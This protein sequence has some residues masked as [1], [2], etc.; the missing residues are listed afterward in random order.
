MTHVTMEEFKSP[1]FRLGGGIL[2][3]DMTFKRLIAEFSD[4]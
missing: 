3:L 4:I 1:A 2:G